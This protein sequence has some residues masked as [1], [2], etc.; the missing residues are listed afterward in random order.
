MR[1]PEREEA[2]P[3]Q[4]VASAFLNTT[5]VAALLVAGWFLAASILH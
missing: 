1:S 2:N 4:T 5:A 3:M